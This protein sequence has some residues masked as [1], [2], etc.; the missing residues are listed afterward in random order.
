MNEKRDLLWSENKKKVEG[1]SIIKNN[2][3]FLLI[4]T[5]IELLFRVSLFIHF[6]LIS[7][8]FVLY[9]FL[10]LACVRRSS[11]LVEMAFN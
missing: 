2:N 11:G 8:Y 9:N 3:N 1:E 10:F 6:V 5:I 4:F 7:L